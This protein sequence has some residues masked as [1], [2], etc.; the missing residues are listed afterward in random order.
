MNFEELPLLLKRQIFIYTDQMTLETCEKMNSF[1]ELF[2]YPNL[3]RIYEERV[4]LFFSQF[5]ID[6]RTEETKWRE[7]YDRMREL[8]YLIYCN[9]VE[10]ISP[11]L[12]TIGALLELQII[13]QFKNGLAIHPT[14]ETACYAAENGH[15]HILEWLYS[16]EPSSAGGGGIKF[17]SRVADSAIKSQRMA[18]IYWLAERGIQPTPKGLM[19]AIKLENISLLN[20]FAIRGRLPPD[21]AADWT[22]LNDKLT[23]FC[24]CLNHLLYPTRDTIDQL[25]PIYLD[26]LKEHGIY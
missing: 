26:L 25:G 19:E 22:A 3:E 14:I 15:I 11:Y 20:Y 7:F 9:E 24:W 21:E 6:F 1:S 5:I 2:S 8:I 23:M 4:H 18:L 16:S 10:N 17:D 12:A 13:D